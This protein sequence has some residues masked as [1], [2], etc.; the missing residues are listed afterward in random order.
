MQGWPPVDEDGDIIWNQP[1]SPL[2]IPEDGLELPD[3]E[4]EKETLFAGEHSAGS[5]MF[6]SEICMHRQL[7]IHKS[8][9]VLEHNAQC[10][11]T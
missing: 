3:N 11:Y 5:G 4:H 9:W 1:I 7:I 2:N 8:C 10:H 6:T